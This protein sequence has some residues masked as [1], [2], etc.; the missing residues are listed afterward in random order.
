MK[1]LSKLFTSSIFVALM[2]LSCV[3]PNTPPINLGNEVD[4]SSPILQLGQSWQGTMGGLLEVT[5][6]YDVATN[7][8]SGTVK[9]ISS[10]KLCWGLSEPHMKLGMTT[11]GELGPEML[12]DLLPGQTVNTNLV[13]NTDPKF[14]GYAFDGYVIHMEVYDCNGG[15][16]PPY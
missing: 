12:G 4:F 11:V 2:V 1:R 7:T 14:T 9:N 10:N 3:K 15:V 8:I 13:V 6:D 5:A 16:P